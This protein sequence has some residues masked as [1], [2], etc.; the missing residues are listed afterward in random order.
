M[1][2]LALNTP[3]T[4]LDVPVIFPR[5]NQTPADNLRHA[6][7]LS[8]TPQTHLDPP[9]HTLTPLDIQE[10]PLRHPATP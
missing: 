1:M 2:A 10:T 6:Q 4:T 8:D 9:S 3:Q 5:L 7:T